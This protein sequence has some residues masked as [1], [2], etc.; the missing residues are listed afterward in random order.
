WHSPVMRGP[1]STLHEMTSKELI[2]RPVHS[3]EI[4]LGQPRR[5]VAA[6]RL[7]RTDWTP[8]PDS[9]AYLVSEGSGQMIPRILQTRH[10]RHIPSPV[11]PLKTGGARYGCI[12]RAVSWSASDTIQSGRTRA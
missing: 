4:L 11:G 1:E 7:P 10:P 2:G 12:R 9:G 5:S 3:W 8:D 6:P